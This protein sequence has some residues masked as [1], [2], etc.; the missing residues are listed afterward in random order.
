MMIQFHKPSDYEDDDS[1][2]QEPPKPPGPDYEDNGTESCKYKLLHQIMYRMR[3]I[4]SKQRSLDILIFSISIF[5][6]PSM[7]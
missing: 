6:M 1:E 2:N 7:F 3:Q 5:Q 4:N